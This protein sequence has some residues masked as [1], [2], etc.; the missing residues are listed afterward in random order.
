MI[1][2][3]QLMHTMQKM[4]LTKLLILLKMRLVNKFLMGL[5]GEGYT[6]FSTLALQGEFNFVIKPTN[7][8]SNSTSS[9]CKAPRTR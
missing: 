9:K 8:F 6:F 5:N 3:L 1:L 2:Q 4:A 7:I